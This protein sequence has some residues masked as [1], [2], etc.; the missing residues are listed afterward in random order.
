MHERVKHA[1]GEMAQQ[2]CKDLPTTGS[3]MDGRES[4]SLD[5]WA[6]Q[7][8]ERVEA[9]RGVLHNH[10][11]AHLARGKLALLSRDLLRLALQLGEVHLL[12][13]QRER[14]L[15]ATAFE[16][17]FHLLELFCISSHKSDNLTIEWSR[18]SV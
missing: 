11:T 8:V 5:V 17:H 1:S 9:Q 4:G 15:L 6:G 10:S 14:Q 3:G 18:R 7:P 2:D 16:E 13:D 12:V